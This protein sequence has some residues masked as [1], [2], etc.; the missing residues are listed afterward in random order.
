MSG[1]ERTNQVIAGRQSG[2]T[3]LEL[4]LVLMVMA[5]VGAVV[6]PN[7]TN[8]IDSLRLR[9][10][11]LLLAQEMRAARTEAIMSQ[12]ARDIRFY[13]NNSY[14]KIFPSNRVIYLSQGIRI[15]E[16]NFP[17]DPLF[18]VHRCRFHAS[19][20]PTGG[21]ISLVNRQGQ[22]KHVIISVYMG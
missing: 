14:Y 15:Q 21:H 20:V 4:L 2:F 3:L 5:V 11:A 1:R 7:L 17:E 8:I 22:Q 13:P 19:G 6:Y 18:Y 16:N 12:E 10:D 9:S